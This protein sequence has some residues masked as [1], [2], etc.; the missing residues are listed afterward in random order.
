M[1]GLFK[2]SVGG[3]NDTPSN[4]DAYIPVAVVTKTGTSYV[5]TDYN[6]SEVLAQGRMQAF[7]NAIKN[8][9]S[10]K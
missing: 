3:A 8:K 2:Y 6:T 10:K 1:T 4:P 5:L 9:K 7:I